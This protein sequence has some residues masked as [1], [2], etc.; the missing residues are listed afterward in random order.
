MKVLGHSS[1]DCSLLDFLAKFFPD[2]SKSTLR[3]WISDGRVYIDGILAKSAKHQVSQG[4]EIA[5]GDK[6]RLVEN[7]IPIIYEDQAIIVIDKPEGLLSVSTAFEKAETAHASL[8]RKY[9]PRPIY[10]VH[11]LDQETSGVMVFALSE[12]SLEQ[13]KKKFEKHDIERRYTGIV[14]GKLASQS[15]C[16]KSYLHENANYVVKVVEDS[17][18]G[19]LAIT[20]Y[21]VKACNKAY[22][23]LELTLETGKKNQIRVHCQHAG[24]PI[25][26][27]KK[28]GSTCNPLKRLGLHAHYLAFSHPITGKAMSFSS[29]VPASFKRGIL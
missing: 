28:Y 29:P 7:Q 19:E 3:S 9:Y 4:Q 18:Q 25:V 21:Q 2:S 8:K 16:W 11:R 10:V 14:E 6:V 12:Q 15:G 17:N 1:E 27:D 20:H 5:L 22:S 23:Q 26:G 24:H 13:L